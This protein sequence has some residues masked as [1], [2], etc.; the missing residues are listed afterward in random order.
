MYYKSKNVEGWNLFRY[1]VFSFAFPSF[2][3]FAVSKRITHQFRYSPT[4]MSNHLFT[5][6]IENSHSSLSTVTAITV[7]RNYALQ[8]GGG[9]NL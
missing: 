4:T 3:C 7:N 9:L 5:S 6:L 1:V 8:N 2:S